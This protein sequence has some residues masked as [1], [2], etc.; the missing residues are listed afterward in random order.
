MI[1]EEINTTNSNKKLPS[2]AE[3]MQI[4]WTYAE[5]NSKLNFKK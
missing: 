5:L 3:E 2:T 1:I 4:M